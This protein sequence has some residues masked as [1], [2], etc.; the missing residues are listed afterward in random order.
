MALINLMRRKTP[1]SPVDAAGPPIAKAPANGA[2]ASIL[3]PNEALYRSLIERVPGIV[4][5]SQF[6]PDAR[7]HYVSPQI[8]EYLG[9]TAEEWLSN[10]ALWLQ[11]VHPEDREL[12]L[13]E[14]QRLHKTG[15]AFFAEYRMVARDGR[16]IWFRDESVIIRPEGSDTPVLYGIL[17]DISER[18]ATESALRESEERLRLA[19][20]AAHLG[21]WEWDP[22]TDALFWDDRH[23]SLFGLDPRRAPA[24][25]AKYLELVHP[26]D[27]EWV[28]HAVREALHSDES[29]GAEYRV[30]W[31]DGKEHW[32]ASAG[33]VLQR[34]AN[35]RARRMRGITYDV[36]DRRG[37]EEHLR[38][39]QKMEAIGQLAGGVA[40]DFNNLL[41][42]IRGHVE[43]LLNRPGV[44]SHVA[45]NAEAIEKA[46]DRAAGITQQ[47]LAFSRKQVLKAHVIEM[48]AVVKDI[49]NL[50]RQLLG[51]MVEFRLQLPQ[52]RLW[53]RAD[54]SQLEQVVLN[55]AVNA[56]DAMPQGG[57][58][59]T[60][61][62][63]VAKDSHA[64]RRRPGM[65]E[66]DYI[67]LR[68]IDTGTGMDA[69]TQAR[70]FEP[71]FTTKEFGK[72]TGL[73]LATVYGVVKQSDGWIWVD[74]EL[75]EGTTFEIFLPAVDAPEEDA[76][77]ND[78]KARQAGGSETILVV[79]DEEGVREVATQ[80][81]SS[82]GYHV[83][84]AES[85]AQALEL[86]G[87]QTGPIHAL[88]TDT[89]MPGMS[90]PALAKK[91]LE[92][93]PSTKVLFISGFAEDTSLLE[94][95]RLR[96]DAFLQ[97]PFG[98]DSLAEKLRALLNN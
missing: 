55:L 95:A 90:G 80:Y 29:Y 23:C 18:K 52:E 93:W 67:R 91:L 31:P 78:A 13:A 50:L 6:G 3:A 79:D 92:Q 9:Y 98:L 32:L 61:L 66:T 47:L 34:D 54:E 64:V 19:L 84:S 89:L 11:H 42:V 2:L 49:A 53:V 8:Q 71:F 65:A 97:K 40:H 70:I 22:E 83:L 77:K 62:D 73:G 24:T 25:A 30:R 45:R 21:M 87:A 39:A 28:L 17:F 63:R 59:T 72:G 35:S 69:A 41:M 26:E 46:S 56:R 75:G 16:I 86:A 58:V 38:R 68:V 5:I 81:L 37:L 20:E 15:S 36:T 48:G 44:D 57:T 82:R 1:T 88:V 96:G 10:P 12:V 85:G 51:P 33:R 74:S 27:R 76:L 14:E 60:I 7:W 4:Y 43:L 94:D